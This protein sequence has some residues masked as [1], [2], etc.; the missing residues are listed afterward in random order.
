MS[1]LGCKSV[2]V[3]SSIHNDC[4]GLLKSQS[5]IHTLPIY[6]KARSSIGHSVSALRRRRRATSLKSLS[7]ED[8]SPPAKIKRNIFFC[9]LKIFPDEKQICFENNEKYIKCHNHTALSTFILQRMEELGIDQ[10]AYDGNFLGPIGIYKELI[11]KIVNIIRRNCGVDCACISESAL[12]SKAG[13]K[14][15]RRHRRSRK[16]HRH[17]RSRKSHRH[18][19]S[20]KSRRHRRSRISRRHQRL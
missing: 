7:V 16:S 3:I 17:R 1:C 14:K 5:S 15:S 10:D 19:R 6:I 8:A 18:R 12:R 20:R 13:G 9:K 2:D 11:D 4:E